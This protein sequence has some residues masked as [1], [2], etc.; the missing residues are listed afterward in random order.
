M[1]SVRTRGTAASI[2]CLSLLAGC[3][4]VDG[5]PLATVTGTVTLDGQPVKGALL[6]F[7]PQ[8]PG[9]S[10]A[11]GGTDESGRYEMLF[12]QSR[13]G[14]VVGRSL[15]RITSDDR[16]SIGGE[17]Y[18]RTEVFPPKYNT[19]SEQYVDVVDGENVF[20]FKCESGEFKPRQPRG[21]SGGK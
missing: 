13:K 17:A 20:D 12:G 21:S 15:V 1:K 4:G 16:V 2:L 14:A 7:V 11:W 8:H 9:G 19:Q 10:T 3:G 6:E 18:E 5:P